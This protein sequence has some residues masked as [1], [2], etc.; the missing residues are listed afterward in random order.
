[1]DTLRG[2]PEPPPIKS[3]KGLQNGSCNRRACQSPGATWFN[4]GTRAYYCQPCALKINRINADYGEP[5][6]LP[7][8]RSI[9]G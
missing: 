4:I 5:I 9:G 2:I 6:C 8:T 1:M 3:D 7:P